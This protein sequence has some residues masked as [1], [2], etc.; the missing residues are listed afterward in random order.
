MKRLADIILALLLLLPAA[1][2]I[3]IAAIAVRLETPG[4]PIFLQTRVGR[5]RRPFKMIKLR[6][7]AK[8]TAA[9]ASHEIGD[10]TITR[11]G[12]FLR[13]SKIDELPQI[14]SVLIGSMS[15][16]GP[17]PCLPMQSELVEERERRGVFALRPGITGKAQ[18]MAI[19]MSQPARL[20]AIDAEYAQERTFW[21]DLVIMLQTAAGGAYFDAA[22]P[23]RK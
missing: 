17:R 8:G 15:F 20:A 5:N 12:R 7:M 2:I 10:S 4:S 9:G 19:D 18:V 14:W 23:S 21:G 16:V 22:A 11:V 13:Q 1:V 6:T 3:G